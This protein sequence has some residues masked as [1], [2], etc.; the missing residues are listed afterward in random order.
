MPF[1]GLKAKT[2][3]WR[4]SI[5]ILG[6]LAVAIV[7]VG[8]LMY[9]GTRRTLYREAEEFLLVEIREVAAY[10]NGQ[11]RSPAEILG[12]L[13]EI[14]GLHGRSFPMEFE[15]V[16]SAGAVARTSGF[17]GAIEETMDLFSV[18]GGKTT[19][20]TS[21]VRSPAAKYPYLLTETSVCLADGKEVRV[22]G[23]TYICTF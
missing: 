7:G 11:N 3:T 22:R 15:V 17:P 12:R 19:G 16:S 8:V 18:L 6:M 13:E 9:V 20:D 10:L 4:L 5:P 14:S 1:G 21:L 23:V 2:L